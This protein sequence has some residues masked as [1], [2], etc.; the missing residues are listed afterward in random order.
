VLGQALELLREGKPARLT[1]PKDAEEERRFAQ[2]QLLTAKPVLYV[3]NVD[4]GDAANGNALSRACS[5][6]PSAEGAEAVVVSA[7]IEAEIATMDMDERARLPRG[8]GPARDR[9]RP[10]HPRRL[11]AAAPDH[12]LHRR[13]QGSARLD[14]QKGA[15]APEA[16]GEIHTDFERGFIRA[17]TIAY[18]DF[19][20]L[21][22]RSRRARRRQ[23]AL[24][25][26]RN[27]SS[28]TATSC[29]SSSTSA[30]VFPSPTGE[31]TAGVIPTVGPV[32]LVFGAVCGFLYM[33][34][35]TRLVLVRLFAT[36]ERFLAGDPSL[37]ASQQRIVSE[38]AQEQEGLDSTLRQQAASPRG[39]T[40]DDALG[41]MFNLL[42]KNNPDKVLQLGA[43]LSATGA[44]NRAE[45]WFYLA[46][47]FGQKLHRLDRGTAE[48]LSARDNALDSA[49]RAAAR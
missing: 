44:R 46:A 24:R 12:L 19:V 43:E 22:R 37:S 17:E 21:R 40:V 13:P 20:A 23:A 47:A 6:R 27:M 9:P 38:I 42:Y 49:R 35:N 7:A 8:P 33:Y 1:K 30:R 2:A 25:K 5:T 45:Y 28:R 41:L 14:G 16:A 11:R 31:L 15:K 34:L 29:C 3:C 48:W 10:R 4:E 32:L 26:A 36:I 18:D 39:W